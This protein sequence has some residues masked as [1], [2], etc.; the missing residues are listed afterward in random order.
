M[1]DGAALLK[2]QEGSGAGLVGGGAT[3]IEGH[4]GAGDD[5]VG[6]GG[7]LEGFCF[8]EGEPT[9][10]GGV[11]AGMANLRLA[12]GGWEE[13]AD[14]I[15]Q[16]VMELSATVGVGHDAFKDGGQEEGLNLQS[17]FFQDFAAE[18]VFEAFAGFDG[19][20]GKTP[21]A[22]QGG[23]SATD[24]E[25]FPAPDDNGPH[26]HNGAGGIAA[27]IAITGS[28]CGFHGGHDE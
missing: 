3:A 22:E 11:I 28:V 17:G 12:S 19:A 21:V 8:V 1:G 13:F 26:A 2:A 10:G 16:H 27:A 6:A 24:Q 9:E 14:V 4:Q 7:H 18:G 20:A 15:Q 25:H 5:I 23:A